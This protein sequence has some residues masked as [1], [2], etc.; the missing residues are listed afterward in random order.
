MI[1]WSNRL[2]VRYDGNLINIHDYNSIPLGIPITLDGIICCWY[3][4]SIFI[5]P[6]FVRCF[7][8]WN[9]WKLK[10]IDWDII[11]G[12]QC[13][14]EWTQNWICSIGLDT[15]QQNV[16]STRTD[17]PIIASNVTSAFWVLCGIKKNLSI[18]QFAVLSTVASY[19]WD[20]MNSFANKDFKFSVHYSGFDSIRWVFQSFNI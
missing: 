3:T 10:T 14:Y 6:G 2:H 13:Q 1:T 16:Y 17:F 11:F 4:L 12:F 20:F 15:G 5:F 8:M 9:T 18:R 7:W 19:Q